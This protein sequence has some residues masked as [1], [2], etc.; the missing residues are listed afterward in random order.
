VTKPKP[1]TKVRAPRREKRPTVR[2]LRTSLDQAEQAL[3]AIRKGD[4]DVLVVGG[5]EGARV[6]TLEGADK[7]YRIL[8]EVLSEGVA[9]LAP[10]GRITYCN[11]RFAA[12]LGA[13]LE[14]TI[15]SSIHELV[16]P[17]DQE[18]FLELLVRGAAERSEG[19]FMLRNV[20]VLLSVVPLTGQTG[21]RHCVVMTDLTEQRRNNDA[22]AAE[23]AALAARLLVVERMSVMG[24]VAAG[25]AHE[26]N[27][28]LAYVI[29]S[30]EL[31]I[32]R[33]PDLSG[34]RTLGSEHVDW[35]QR[36]LERAYEGAAR[37]RVIVRDLKAFSRA[38]DETVKVVDLRRALDASIALVSNE[39][40][41]RARLVRDYD[42]LP[43]VRANQ[44]RLE[45]VFVNLLANAAQAIPAGAAD[46]HEIRISGHVDATGRAVVEIRDTGSGIPAENLD[47]IFEPFFTTKAVGVG[48]GLGLALSH[49]I[50]SAFGGQLSVESAPGATVFRV[51]LAIAER[52]VPV[53]AEA[54]PIDSRARLLVIDDEKDL[55]EVLQEALAPLH[56]VVGTTRARQ[57]LEWIAA[58][59]RFDAILCDMKMPEMTG[60]D[61]YAHLLALHPEQAARVTLMSGGFSRNEKDATQSF[62]RAILEKPF[63]VGQVRS[64]LRSS[65]RAQAPTR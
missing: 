16:H 24:V 17:N 30:L 41:L 65:Q 55:M 18:Q 32:G 43:F 46:K 58:G 40:A 10:E 33:L 35:M 44:A 54:I 47:R 39:I 51:V 11:A 22:I 49:G 1:K 45:Q 59:E 42:E 8:L 53:E 19:E 62:P 57:A 2:A 25:V 56:E 29:A 36:Q 20:P 9:K 13:P 6:F 34:G 52:D 3:A 37:V 15:G 60:L 23:R 4:V 63:D 31:M 26:I 61:F 48:T 50:V 27:N 7:G 12:I 64:L 21:E 28:P 5:P 14:R 38:D